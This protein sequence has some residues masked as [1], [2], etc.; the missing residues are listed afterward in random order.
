MLRGI[1]VRRPFRVVARSVGPGQD[2]P[3]PG[4]TPA[5]GYDPSQPRVDGMFE[6]RPIIGRGILPLA[7][8]ALLA[9]GTIGFLRSRNGDEVVDESRPPPAP[10]DFAAEAISH[11]T[12]RLSWE[13]GDRVDTYRL[14]T[15]DPSTIEQDKP[16]AVD[17]V[18]EIPGD[19]GAFDVG[20]LT[21]STRYCF[22]LA[23]LRNGNPSPRTPPQCVDTL[24]LQGPGA[25]AAP[26]DVQVDVTDDGKARVSWQSDAESTA[27]HIV[28]RNGSVAE[29]VTHPKSEAVVDLADGENCFQV[30]AKQGEVASA[31]A[32]DPCIAVEQDGGTDATTSTTGDG[33]GGSTG[34]TVGGESG[35]E[36]GVIAVVEA[37]PIE[38]VQA[39][40]RAIASRDQ[41]RQGGQPT[42]GVLDTGDFPALAN[43]TG[44]FYY[45][46]VPG[47]ASLEDAQAFCDANGFTSCLKYDLAAE[48]SGGSG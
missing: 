8:I 28:L 10:A 48:P 41:L 35:A 42:A 1:P 3:A 46:F 7:I 31:P 22:Q 32:P 17:V 33:I 44:N 36:L 25:P 24:Q 43:P 11:D 26:E 15:V 30:Q 2:L 34:G 9:A 5:L 39:L 21:P 12:I 38:D 40:Q 4:P 29:V 45:V 37:I 13:P 47:F 6:Q 18:E 27:D 20:E 23:A 14:M 19:Q 16:R